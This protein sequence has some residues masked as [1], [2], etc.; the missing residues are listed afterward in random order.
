[1]ATLTTRSNHT[2]RF[3]AQ[4]LPDWLHAASLEQIQNLRKRAEENRWVEQRLKA[5]FRRMLGPESFARQTLTA[6][7]QQ[8]LGVSIDLTHALWRERLDSYSLLGGEALH[9]R[10]TFHPAITHL[11]Q[12]FPSG[13][14]FD[15]RSGIIAGAQGMS[16]TSPLLVS[17]AKLAATCR[18]VDTGKRYQAYLHTFLDDAA[19]TLIA[20]GVR[21]RLALAVEAAGVRQAITQADVTSLEHTLQEVLAPDPRQPAVVPKHL[22]VLGQALLG[23]LV[24]ELSD[25]GA[26]GL[27]Y[28]GAGVLLY[29]PH[30]PLQKFAD[31]KSLNAHLVNLFRQPEQA[32]RLLALVA[33]DA[34]VVFQTTLNK[35]L[36]DAVPDLEVAGAAGRTS[37]FLEMADLQVERI[38]A[39]ARFLLVPVAEVDRLQRLQRLQTLEQVGL[40]LA[41]MAALFVPQL[42]ELMLA[43]TV[44]EVLGEVGVAVYDWSRGHQHEAMEHVL[45]VAEVVAVTALTAVGGA[46]VARGFKRSTFVDEMVPVER[47][48]AAHRL[49]VE[50][51]KPYRAV[52]VSR[53]GIRGQDGLF[54]HGNRHWW[55]HDGNYYAV[56]RKTESSPWRLVRNDGKA[57]FAPALSWNGE[58]GWRLRFQRPQTWSGGRELLS[59]LWPVSDEFDAPRTAQLL[60]AADVDQDLLRRAVSEQR[61]MPVRLRDTLEHF[62][63]DARIDRFFATFERQQGKDDPSLLQ[64]CL[65]QLT[66]QQRAPDSLLPSV[67]AHAPALREGLMN[68]LTRKPGVSPEAAVIQRTFPG[69]PALYAEDVIA[70]ASAEQCQRLLAQGRLDLALAEKARLALQE[71]RACRAV[72]GLYL[73]NAYHP[74]LPALVFGLLRQEPAWPLGLNVQVREASPAGRILA[75]LYP[76]TDASAV[77]VLVWERGQMAVY[78]NGKRVSDSFSGAGGLLD[79]LWHLLPE[80]E[81]SR[82][83]WSGPNGVKALRTNLQAR[84]PRQRKAVQELIGMQVRQPS[85]R[86]PA[87]LPDRRFGYLLS[88]RGSANHLAERTLQD[89]VRSL[90][91]GFSSRQL[92]LFLEVLEE[93]PGSPF[94]HLLELESE[95]TRLDLTLEQWAALPAE[96][97]NVVRRRRVADELRRCWRFQG[98]A[99]RRQAN[100][101]PGM[102]LSLSGTGV[103]ELPNLS[104]VRGFTHVSELSLV[105][106]RLGDVPEHFLTPFQSISTLSLDNNALTQLPPALSQLRQLQELTL[107]RN[108]LQLDDA[109][110]E[111]LAGM[112]R[113]SVLDLS[114]NSIG[115]FTIALDR[116]PRLRQLGLRRVGLTDVPA[117][118]ERAVSL[119]YVDLRDNHINELPLP[120]RAQRAHWRSRLS[121]VGNPLPALYRDLWVDA[122]RTSDSEISTD[123]DAYHLSRWVEQL[124]PASRASRTAQW[125][126]LQDES[127]S[128]DFF[129]LLAE[130][131]ETS[132]FRLARDD[133]QAR[134]WAMLDSIESN[135][136]LREQTFALA[137]EPRT[138]V[139]SVISSFGMLEV[140]LLSASV[141]ATAAD[142]AEGELL[143]LARR[144]FRLDQVEA[145][146]RRDMGSR[147]ASGAEVDQVEV[148]LAYRIGLARTLELPGQATT[149]QFRTLAGVTQEHLEA[150]EAAVRAAEA[151][152]DLAVDI[153]E[154]GFW[155][156]HLQ[157]QHRTSFDLVREPFVQQMEVLYAEREG[158]TD[159]QYDSQARSIA[160]ACDEAVKAKALELTRQ[161]LARAGKQ[162]PT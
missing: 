71:A 156:D 113:L 149:M 3:I 76:V 50:D 41:Q 48:D 96:A 138:C 103:G 59:H 16:F 9:A 32:S 98:H 131:T 121:L 5:L 37:L 123:G 19:S 120:L 125:S 104:G 61:S 82:L 15:A 65:G 144:F 39:D 154:R 161:A 108:N 52:G 136:A 143:S 12:N 83:G 21:K 158:L 88:G 107:S 151:G 24:I 155:F 55:L 139:D 126:R 60:N 7:I 73:E 111:V 63:A 159:A 25:G 51:L 89:R 147:Q 101:D 153:S 29:L 100:G 2:D 91:P 117:H 141:E 119:E 34:R 85:F 146:A 64:W 148:S 160:K 150:A 90:Y 95:Y 23:G 142:Q 145:Y 116:L 122:S 75:E 33:A 46:A 57:E 93:Q 54:R 84:I 10:Y 109:G 1:M 45:G 67:L 43:A 140:R 30:R 78:E 27:A 35:R 74:D 13:S 94:N 31:L 66:E 69:L 18:S 36:A 11:M 130:L 87:R 86:S 6:A 79:R 47:D 118:L 128:D 56:G 102:L 97:A 70:N 42:G 127:G 99:G 72:Q 17:S 134:V 49:W 28:P 80:A 68:H 62:E 152:D 115:N 162:L 129:M 92:E 135:T 26:G 14:G 40:N 124:D 22:Q 53:H 20:Q 133:L 8:Q 157:R 81:R 4:Q 38:K 105:N 44:T 114:E 77:K 112:S 132:D 110:F 58:H 106:M 137:S